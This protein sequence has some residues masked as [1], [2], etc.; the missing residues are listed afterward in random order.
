MRSMLSPPP[1]R[2]PPIVTMHVTERE[3]RAALRRAMLRAGASAWDAAQG[4][5]SPARRPANHRAPRLP[6]FSGT[7]SPCL[8][9]LFDPP[10]LPP[11]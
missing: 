9:L 3:S 8:L 6:V 10:N 4:G 2:P 5:V 7:P 1:L 11:L